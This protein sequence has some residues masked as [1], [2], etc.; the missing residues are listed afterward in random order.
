VGNDREPKPQKG[1]I[2]SSDHRGL[3]AYVGNALDLIAE[4]PAS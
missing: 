3:L 2:M 4:E 1:R